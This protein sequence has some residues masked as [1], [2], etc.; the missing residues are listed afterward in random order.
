MSY[1]FCLIFY[2]YTIQYKG[3][4]TAISGYSCS[5]CICVVS[6][7]VTGSIPTPSCKGSNTCYLQVLISLLSDR[8]TLPCDHISQISY[9]FFKAVYFT[10]LYWECEIVSLLKL[11]GAKDCSVIFVELAMCDHS[12]APSW[13][14]EHVPGWTSVILFFTS[15]DQDAGARQICFPSVLSPA[16]GARTERAS[17]IW[18]SAGILPCVYL[19]LC[20]IYF[21]FSWQCCNAV[22][23]NPGLCQSQKREYIHDHSEEVCTDKKVL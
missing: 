2:F 6:H 20:F 16:A 14:I 12:C 3:K 9:L 23:P 19:K 10:N 5:A 17:P 15:L 4:N 8:F 18:N 7:V 1:L 22:Q 11:L 21:S 13:Q